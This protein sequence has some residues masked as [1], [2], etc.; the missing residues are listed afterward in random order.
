MFVLSVW[1]NAVLFAVELSL[2]T[3]RFLTPVNFPSCR[4]LF[5]GQFCDVAF[6]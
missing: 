6:F 4:K 2:F 1:K 5:V 3:K